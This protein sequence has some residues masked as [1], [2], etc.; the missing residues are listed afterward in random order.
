MKKVIVSACLIGENCKYNGGN[1][2]SEAVL[3]FV[4]DREVIA[5]CPERLAGLG[6]PRIPIEIR[7]GETVDQNGRSVEKVLRRAVDEIVSGI[8]PCEIDCA[9]LKSRSP[10]CGVKEVYDGTFSGRLVP[11]MGM[12]ASTLR[13][14]GVK[15]VDSEDI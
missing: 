2:K 1:N 8:E 3:R 9:I 10:T 14:I 15:V 5:V 12:L 4:K 7:N 11:G 13:D 6:V